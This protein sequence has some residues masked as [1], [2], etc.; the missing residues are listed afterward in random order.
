MFGTVNR[1]LYRYYYKMEL[2]QDAFDAL[3][4]KLEKLEEINNNKD[5][6]LHEERGKRQS[7]SK[8]L[9]SLWDVNPEDLEELNKLR[10]EKKKMEDKKLKEKWKY[11][12]LLKEKETELEELKK[13]IEGVV[14]Y[15]EKYT[16]FM[17]KQ[18]ETKIDEFPEEKKEFIKKLIEWKEHESQLEL[19]EW[20]KKEFGGDSFW[21]IPKTEWE[22]PK[23][24]T[25]FDEAKKKWDISS[26][27]SNAPVLWE[28]Q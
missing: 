18:L 22:P 20:F 19:L 4:K 24:N 14:W 2:T 5:K 21:W 27:L 15:K 10:E 25:E 12:E 23:N 11:E 7:L 9:E 26:M 6:A 16:S 3:T 8:K 1:Y 13:Q 17:E 28:T